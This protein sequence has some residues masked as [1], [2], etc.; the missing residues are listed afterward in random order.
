M[1]AVLFDMDGILVDSVGHW[2]DARDR[3]IRNQLGIEGFDVEELIGLNVH[4]EYE[5]LTESHSIPI[6]VEEYVDLIDEHS[7]SIYQEKVELLPGVR[8]VIE[9]ASTE[10]IALGVV[11]ASSRH[12]VEMVLDR[13][14]LAQ[15]FDVVVGADDIDGDSKPAPDLY[16]TAMDALD[17]DPDD[18]I[19]VEDSVHGVMAARSAG[20]YCIRYD[21]EWARGTTDADETIA[22]VHELRDRLLELIERL[23]RSGT[24][25][26]V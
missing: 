9:R 18:T 3:V 12:R 5:L 1:A 6:S 8:H 23:S 16:L 20:A 17:V 25:G 13:F 14:D 21:H 4:D 10:G 2:C 22:N 26:T 11:S 24:I 15:V 19:V 7:S